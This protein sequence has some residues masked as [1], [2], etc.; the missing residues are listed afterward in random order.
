MKLKALKKCLQLYT[1][2]D[3]LLLD[4][5]CR[6]IVGRLHDANPGLAYGI[7]K[8]S[9]GAGNA[10]QPL[11]DDFVQDFVECA[12]LAY[13]L[14]VLKADKRDTADTPSRY[15]GTETMPKEVSWGLRT[16]IADLF[17]MVGYELLDATLEPL[18]TAAPDLLVDIIRKI[19]TQSDLAHQRIP[20]IYR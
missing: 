18:A 12:R 19:K 10:A 20:V 3:F 9:F 6:E 8:K 1:L 5:L 17:E 7:A 14:P 13:S 2:A 4:D 11:D 16:A 15:T